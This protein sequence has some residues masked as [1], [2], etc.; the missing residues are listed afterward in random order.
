MLIGEAAR[1]LWTRVSFPENNANRGELKMGVGQNSVAA[2]TAVV[3]YDLAK[4][5]IWQRSAQSRALN[6]FGIKGSAAANDTKIS[7]YI[8]V[9]KIGEFY[10]TDTGF[11][12]MDNLIPL[13]GN[14]C[15]SGADIHVYVDD[16]PATNP[17]N[18]MISWQELG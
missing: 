8:D 12:N 9:V 1:L 6:G 13:S 17:V 7:L 5:T 3:G 14:Y 11:P 15:P 16:A 2:A 4:D 10:N 18:I